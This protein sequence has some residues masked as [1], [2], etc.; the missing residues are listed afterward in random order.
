MSQS[1]VDA[2]WFRERGGVPEG[3]RVAHLF[4]NR[5]WVT[6]HAA[7]GD[8][9]DPMLFTTIAPADVRRCSVCARIERLCVRLLSTGETVAGRCRA[10]NGRTSRFP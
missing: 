1:N 5:G 9:R 8:A 6:V 2:E 7:C 3:G 10:G 4:P